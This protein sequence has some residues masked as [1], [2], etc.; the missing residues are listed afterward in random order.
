[1]S[2]AAL[3]LPRPGPA[4]GRPTAPKALE[5]WWARGVAPVMA[6]GHRPRGWS[7]LAVARQAGRL[8][9]KVTLL[10]D[11]ELRARVRITGP[12]LRQ[13]HRAADF[14]LFAAVLREVI[15]RT[16]GLRLN[17]RQLQ[18]GAAIW[19]GMVAEMETGEGKTVTAILPAAAAAMAGEMV[20]VITVNDY[21]AAR[22][23]ETTAPVYAFLGIRT[24]LVVR[25]TPPEARWEVYRAPVVYGSNAEI[26]FDHLRDRTEAVAGSSAAAVLSGAPTARARPPRLP[27]LDRA[28]VDEADSVLIDEARTPLI[29]S[30]DGPPL[31]DAA[32]CRAAIALARTLRE[33]RD[34][35]L[36]PA[37]HEVTLT[38]A[39][40]DRLEAEPAAPDA[41]PRWQSAVFRDDLVRKALSALHLYA[42]GRDYVLQEGKVQ[43]VDENT[44]RI[45]A[46]RSWSMGL[47]QLIETKEGLDPT[48]ERRTL[49][50]LTY[51]S[52]FGR[53]AR[54]GGMTGTISE[55]AVELW[56]VYGLKTARIPTHQRSRRRHLRD[57]VY[58]SEAAREAALLDR[59]GAL[60]ARGV[61]V[62]VGTRTV[63]ASAALSYSLH[64]AGLDHALLNAENDAEEAA[65]IARAGA[66]GRITIATNMAGRGTDIRL[67]P[68]SR[69]AGGLHVLLTD[70]HDSRRTDRQLQGRAARQ[71]DAGSCEAH[72]SLDDRLLA[73]ARLGPDL[74]LAKRLAYWL[75]PLRVRLLGLAQRRLERAH[76]RARF[77]LMQSE[78]GLD[79]T[80]A[81]TGSRE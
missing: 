71:G 34:F 21:L 18:G 60:S 40:R 11:D 32:T 31:Y 14:A 54:V 79:R 30:G 17:R 39:C 16:L 76:G 78:A 13:R 73:P 15:R 24:G 1:M 29:L 26:A 36:A 66:P 69:E 35:R 72:L 46:D 62:L 67:D 52:L 61:P 43:I 9:R 53:Y 58:R 5:R 37:R 74:R 45:F 68:A 8:E 2:D 63:E 12:L 19:R 6:A 77:A 70:R 3:F 38:R 81:F 42:L 41:G 56:R 7:C 75:P 4:P 47:H 28:I 57:R 20:H 64:A 23:L 48:P 80:L 49:G 25:D 65:I 50:R 59:I 10:S 55:A 44:G 27:R 33:G 22:D 51:Q